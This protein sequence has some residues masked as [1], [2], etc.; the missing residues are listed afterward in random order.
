MR[1]R[2]YQKLLEDNIPLLDVNIT[3]VQYNSSVRQLNDYIN[4]M[5]AVHIFE[6]NNLFMDSVEIIKQYEQVYNN[7]QEPFIVSTD[8]ANS[9][10]KTVDNLCQSAKTLKNT[11]ETIITSE[12]NNCMYFK[13]PNYTN[14]EEL[15]DFFDALKTILYV[16]KYAGSEPEFRGF[17]VGSEY[18]V[19]YF[20]A[21]NLLILL[22]Q[23]LD[24]SIALRNKKLEGDKTLAEIEK[25]KSEKRNLDINSFETVI[26][27][28]HD[29]NTEEYNSLR[30]AIVEEITSTTKININKKDENEFKN[31][32]G[33]ALEKAGL[34][35]EKGMKLIPALSAT[36]EI[37][38]A[39]INLNKHITTYQ[40]AYIGINEIRLLSDKN[41]HLKI[42]N[43]NEV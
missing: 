37:T 19:F 2:D 16:F 30:N 25:L 36:Q 18:V 33:K 43:E 35:L 7:D 3:S 34:L 15:S 6:N 23:I 8:I 32:I 42:N 41:E 1:L 12:D 17:D 29:T 22:Y 20:G 11:L 31:H 5:K 27:A 4:A 24:K 21:V 26:K 40:N 28:L 39:T 14:I 38:Q 13:L 9:I 10:K